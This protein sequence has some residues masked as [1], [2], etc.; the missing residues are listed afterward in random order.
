MAHSTR[1]LKWFNVTSLDCD[2]NNKKDG[3]GV[4]GVRT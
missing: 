4:I 1:A 2:Y 3:L